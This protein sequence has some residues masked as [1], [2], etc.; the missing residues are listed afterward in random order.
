[1]HRLQ[2]GVPRPHVR[3][4][5]RDLHGQSA[6]GPRDDT[7]PL[8]TRTTKKVAVVGAGPAGL[9]AAAELSG[10]GHAV[11]L[12]EALPEVGGQ[13]RLA[14]QIPGKE[15]F[16]ETIRYFS[17]PA[18][19]Q[20]R[21]AA[22][23]HAGRRRRAGRFRRSRHRVRRRAAHPDDPPASTIPRSSTTSRSSAARSPSAAPLPWSAPVASASTSQSSCCT[24][25][26]S[27]WS[28]G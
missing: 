4:Q 18:R 1:M 5:A 22:P 9:A 17:P 7:D 26:T 10:R 6:R 28:T 19:D 3:Q 12:F 2:P 25:Q 13:F 11:E 23:R 16:K 8:P 21:Q 27:R 20:R 24:S 15:E 14:M